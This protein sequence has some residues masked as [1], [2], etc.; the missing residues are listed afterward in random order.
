MSAI[1]HIHKYVPIAEVNI[2][3]RITESRQFS[4][5]ICDTRIELNDIWTCSITVAEGFYFFTLFD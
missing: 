2:E 3:K 5:F 4:S 1:C